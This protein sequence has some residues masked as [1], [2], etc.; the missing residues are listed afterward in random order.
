MIDQPVVI[1]RRYGS[2]GPEWTLPINDGQ[3]AEH[4][5]NV[6]RLG[7]ADRAPL[8][9]ATETTDKL[10]TTLAGIPQRTEAQER[11]LTRLNSFPGKNATGR[12]TQVLQAGFPRFMYF[13]HYDRMAGQIRFDD[14]PARIQQTQIDIEDQLFL[15]FLK[16]AGTSVEEINGATTY[17]GLNARCEASSAR[18]TDQVLEYWTQNP[19]LTVEIR[20][21]KAE[22]N[23]PPP[24]NAGVIGRARVVNTLHRASV[25]FSERSAGFV[26]FFS[27]LVKFAQVQADDA[28]AVL[29]LDEPGLTLHGKAQ[30]D[31]LR[32]FDRE[33]SPKHQVAYSTHSPFMVPPERLLD[34]RIVEDRVIVSPSGRRQPEGTKVRD[35]VLATDPD[36][37]FP[38]QG[39]LGYKATQTLFVG[40]HTLLVEGPSDILFLQAWSSALGRRGRTRLDP[41]WT[42]CPSG[43][44]DKIQ[45]FV[46][47]FSGQRLQ[48]AA[49]TDF[50][51]GDK[52]KLEAIRQ[53]NVVA[54]GRL[55]D[56]ATLLGQ[57]EA[58]V[59]DVFA[60]EVYAQIINDAF[61]LMG[62][63]K[64]TVER[65][66]TA[67]PPTPRLLKRTEACFRV[68]S[69]SAREFDHFRP[70]EWLFVNPAILDGDTLAVTA[71]LDRAE[72]VIKAL[73][74]LLPYT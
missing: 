31:L 9:N 49:L 74:A 72:R 21:T 11:L 13:S 50:A 68:M 20:I 64:L 33:L 4:L 1:V 56:F 41:R 65:L 16:F 24:F 42:I 39:A 32:F 35:D 23:D 57:P 18:I 40:K 45:S 2:E 15:D 38:L 58:D 54:Q 71:T 60:P 37:L 5:L 36:T 62:A 48:I 8:L 59:E 55:L 14:L 44:I 19:D 28:A 26:W 61:R 22:P 46:S 69:P 51:Q 3:A 12:I 6:E 52:R 66:Q 34:V 17:E 70:A 53:M 63:D 47:L 67:Q 25:P 29:L 27:F 10:R 73:N 30:A 7:D 43:G